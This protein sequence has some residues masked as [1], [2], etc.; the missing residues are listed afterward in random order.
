MEYLPTLWEFKELEGKRGKIG[1]VDDIIKGVMNIGKVEEVLEALEV[2]CRK[3]VKSIFLLVQYYF[4]VEVEED[5][6]K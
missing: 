2:G 3:S 1:L 4:A 6:K 5:N